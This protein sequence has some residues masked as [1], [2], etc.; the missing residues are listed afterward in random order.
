MCVPDWILAMGEIAGAT[1]HPREGN[2]STVSDQYLVKGSIVDCWMC[3]IATNPTL[4]TP[5]SPTS[6]LIDALNC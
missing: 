2:M 1:S 5:V 6:K 3:T 4:P